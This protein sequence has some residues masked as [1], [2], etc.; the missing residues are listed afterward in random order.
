M[1]L[2]NSNLSCERG[3]KV[4]NFSNIE[5]HDEQTLTHALVITPSKPAR[6][7][8]SGQTLSQ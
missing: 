2:L 6:R 1:V 8:Q 5:L 3:V 7:Q 4:V